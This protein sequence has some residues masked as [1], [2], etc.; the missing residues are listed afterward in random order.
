MSDKKEENEKRK[1]GYRGIR[2]YKYDVLNAYKGMSHSDWR[3]M[4]VREYTEIYESGI[5]DWLFFIFHDKDIDDGIATEL[6]VHFV[7]RFK[8]GRTRSAVMKD[9]CGIN[10]RVENC[11]WVDPKKGGYKSLN[12]YLTHHSEDA[13]NKN[14]TWYPHTEVYEFGAKYLEMIKTSSKQVVDARDMKESAEELLTSVSKGKMTK[15]MAV[16]EFEELHGGLAAVEYT[17]KFDVAERNF[18]DRKIE[19]LKKRNSDSSWLRLTTYVTG[20]GQS[21][22]TRTALYMAEKYADSFGVHNVAGGGG[23]NL[24]YDIVDGYKNE[25]VAVLD[26]VA[27]SSFTSREFFK[28][29]D[30]DN[31]S[32]SKSRNYNKPWFP[33]RVFL[34]NDE[35]LGK[36]FLQMIF[37]TSTAYQKK[38]G[39]MKHFSSD[40]LMGQEELN[41]RKGTIEQIRMIARRVQNY[42]KYDVLDD[43]T[44]IVR[45]FKLVN[46]YPTA[47]DIKNYSQNELNGKY[48]YRVFDIFY[49]DVGY[50][51][52]K[53]DTKNKEDFE[54]ERR[55]IADILVRV[56]DDEPKVNG[57]VYN[58][59]LTLI[60]EMRAKREKDERERELR[61]QR[62]RQRIADLEE[63]AKKYDEIKS[64]K[65]EQIELEMQENALL[66]KI[67]DKMPRGSLSNPFEAS[68]FLDELKKSIKPIV[69]QVDSGTALLIQRT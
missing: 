66:Q 35:D 53:A 22:K 43:G 60:S 38:T 31:W 64:I 40:E 55:V 68:A 30:R 26:D 61:Q 33:E 1:R 28:M 13:Y 20:P 36:F 17:S 21:G 5:C 8:S 50:Y 11:E 14:K 39:N 47:D 10:D 49:H 41:G 56:L 23:R 69:A 18:A 45:L 7:V 4:I 46:D 2:S 16:M 29:F 58:Y 3:D 15:T 19:E 9:L 27:S 42:V 62:E 37:Y 44:P 57:F 63:K 32:I 12:R 6:H 24:T 48:D 25:K 54:N 52:Y 51:K 34:T 59:Q 65:S 67:M